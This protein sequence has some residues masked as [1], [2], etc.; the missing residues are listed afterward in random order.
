MLLRP[1]L[2]RRRSAHQRNTLVIL[3]LLFFLDAIFLIKSR[4]P[5]YT[6]PTLPHDQPTR[7]FIASIHRNNEPIL[8]ASWN[9]AVLRLTLL[10][11]PQNV[12]FSAVESG[13]QDDTKGALLELKGN[14]DAIGVSNDISLGSTVWEQLDELWDRPDP[15]G[16]RVP[17]WIW[18]REDGHYDLRRIPYL[19]RVRNQA[20]EPL[21]RLEGAGR[22]FDKVFWLNDVAFDVSPLTTS[23]C[24]IAISS[25]WFS[26][27]LPS[28]P[29]I[30]VAIRLF[31]YFPC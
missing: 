4:P 21:K 20:M 22:L 19:A 27:S 24:K 13:S 16:N 31:V 23:C 9:D 6:H 3:F 10:L 26:L 8:R 17:G 30:A 7:V 14:L 5:T 2:P 18:N 1:R 12:H 25:G 29:A 15:D 28:S 11:G